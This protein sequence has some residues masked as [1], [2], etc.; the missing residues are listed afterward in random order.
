M[1]FNGFS[2]HPFQGYGPGSNPG[3]CSKSNI[4]IRDYLKALYFIGQ[5]AS[6][7]ELDVN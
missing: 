4:K 3:T 5:I 2:M 6:L 1:V 7:R